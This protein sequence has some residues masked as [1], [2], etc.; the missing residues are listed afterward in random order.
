MY[1]ANGPVNLTEAEK[2]EYCIDALKSKDRPL[3]SPWV[4]PAKGTNEYYEWILNA[5]YARVDRGHEGMP[6]VFV[7]DE[8][9]V[10]GRLLDQRTYE[11]PK[12]YRRRKSRAARSIIN[13]NIKPL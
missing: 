3:S 2:L 5:G 13:R 12:I 6:I 11:P 1:T 8:F 7:R 9:D 4:G 10:N